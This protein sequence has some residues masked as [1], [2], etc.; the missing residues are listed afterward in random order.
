MFGG[1]AK[2]ENPRRRVG[3]KVC[4]VPPK[5]VGSLQAPGDIGHNII[6]KPQFG[7]HGGFFGTSQAS[8]AAQHEA[9]A[10]LEPMRW[11]STRREASELLGVDLILPIPLGGSRK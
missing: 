10:A 7:G 2:E 4:S 9:K 1:Y 3:L 5:L 11:T 6:P 8:R